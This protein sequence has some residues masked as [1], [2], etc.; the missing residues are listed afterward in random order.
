MPKKQLSAQDRALELLKE[1]QKLVRGDRRMA[2]AN[3]ISV[4][5]KSGK[6]T[7]VITAVTN[8]VLDNM[9]VG[10]KISDPEHAKLMYRKSKGKGVTAFY[11]WR[12]RD[13]KQTE[14]VIGHYPAMKLSG[15]HDAWEAMRDAETASTNPDAYKLAKEAKERAAEQSDEKAEVTVAEICDRYIE[16]HAK[17]FKKTWYED[18]RLLR[19]FFIAE[20]GKRLACQITKADIDGILHDLERR[21]GRE[22]QKVRAVISKLYNVAIA[23]PV[24]PRH[25][26]KG[27]QPNRISWLPEGTINPAALTQKSSYDAQRYSPTTA[28]LQGLMETVTAEARMPGVDAIAPKALLLQALTFSRINEACAARWDQID[29]KAGTWTLPETATKNGQEH[30][31][32]LSDQA[33]SLLSNTKRTASPFVF[34]SIKDPQKSIRSNSVQHWWKG[35]KPE[36]V[37]ERFGSHGLRRAGAAFVKGIGGSEDVRMRLLNHHSSTMAALY[38]AGETMDEPARKYGQ[39]W[40]D[41]LTGL[42]AGNVVAIGVKR[43]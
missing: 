13:G 42:T 41:Y 8:L 23:A 28:D 16:E 34:P 22:A 5:E 19:K 9:S 32:M 3:A 20:H 35:S 15:I 31:V 10:D 26:K 4:L 2:I 30:T 17:P 24:A 14:T 29:L 40:A 27:Q 43:A 21:S 18:Q 7:A 12:D 1:A 39:H 33:V 25:M 11:R 38:A 36:G 37:H 6:I